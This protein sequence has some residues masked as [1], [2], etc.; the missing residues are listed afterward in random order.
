ME[1]RIDINKLNILIFF[2]SLPIQSRVIVIS[3][4]CQYGSSAVWPVMACSYKL[5][6]YWY[7]QA[8]LNQYWLTVVEV[9]LGS[10]ILSYIQHSQ[11]DILCTKE[12]I[13]HE[14]IYLF[15]YLFRSAHC[16][17]EYGTSLNLESRTILPKS[18]KNTKNYKSYQQLGICTF[19]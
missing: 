6:T 2:H 15:R 19:S 3:T 10:W 11:R 5:S 7:W 13:L 1:K 9:W 18:F 4:G 17:R 16:L 12:V 8:V 14:Y